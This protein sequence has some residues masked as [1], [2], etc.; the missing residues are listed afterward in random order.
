MSNKL[1]A[2]FPSTWFGRQIP[3]WHTLR[4]HSGACSNNIQP[5]QRC[6]TRNDKLNGF[7]ILEMILVVLI[8]GIIS[9]MAILNTDLAGPERKS[10]QLVRSLAAH[11]KLAGEESIFTSQPYGL[12]L[13]E[14]AYKFSILINGSW[15]TLLS[16]DGI[17]KSPFLLPEG[18][19]FD[20]SKIDALSAKN[21]LQQDLKDKIK[22]KN[23]ARKVK[24]KWA[25][26]KDRKILGK[27]EK[28]NQWRIDNNEEMPDNQDDD[29]DNQGNDDDDK[30]MEFGDPALLFFSTGE[31]S[32][33]NI[34]LVYEDNPSYYISG[35]AFGDVEIVSANSSDE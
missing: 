34:I 14:N 18:F 27:D 12:H 4:R 20:L 17:W 1:T 21:R 19:H 16:K 32:P 35:G 23:I 15:V 31:R 5:L 29:D 25:D 10:L 30:E 3:P 8:I 2:T 6:P 24:K 26:A 28:E 13:N 11:I 22:V 9:S 7:T 33:F